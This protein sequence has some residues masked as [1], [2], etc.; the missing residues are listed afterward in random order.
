MVNLV[1]KHTAGY[2]IHVDDNRKTFKDKTYVA[3]V[4]EPNQLHKFASY[5]AL[6]TLSAL[7]KSDLENT[8]FMDGAPHDII[9]R[10]SGIADGNLASHLEGS[11]S[12]Q[13]KMRDPNYRKT[14]SENER[15]SA[16]L[17]KSART[18]K[19]DRDMYFQSVEIKA[20]P[21]PNEKRRLTSVV[22]MT[23]NIIE[24]AGIT[25]FEKLR[26]AAF[27]NG[28]FDHIDHP[29]LLTVEFTGFDTN[30]RIMTSNETKNMKRLIP[31]KLIDVQMSVNQ[32]GTEYSVKAIP[33]NEFGFM[34]RF[35]YVRTS[36]TLK[37]RNR[38]L[39]T[40][41][42]ALENLL[43]E[44]NESE[45]TTAGVSIPDIY[46]ISIDRSFEADKVE[47]DSKSIE[48]AGM[49]KQ[50]DVT[51]AD[52]GFYG[53]D[54]DIPTIDVMKVNTGNAISKI[55]EDIMKSHPLL[56]DV[57]FDKWKSK[58]ASTLLG[59]QQVSGSQGVY[60][61]ATDK[62]NPDM[63]FPYFKVKSAVTPLDR[64]D[65]KRQKHQKLIHFIVEPYEVHAYSLAIPGVSTGD[66]F[67]KFVYKTY[68]YMFTGENVDVL[69]C[70][71]DYKYS[72]FQSRLK[73]VDASND[74]QNFVE[75]KSIEKQPGIANEPDFVHDGAFKHSFEPGIAANEKTGP[76][77]ETF[78]RV[79]QFIDELTH[80]L[81]DMV[82]IRL[83]ILGDPAWIGQSQFIPP[84]PKKVGDGITQDTDIVYWRG[85]K[86]EAIWNSK[87]KCYNTDLAEPI[88]MLRFK[89]PTDVDTKK[90]VYEMGVTEQA[91]FSGLYRVISMEHNF[92][93]GKYT[94]ILELTRFNNQGV[95]ISDPIEDYQTTDFK[96]KVTVPST[97]EE[98]KNFKDNFIAGATERVTNIGK[99]VVKD[100]TA[101]AKKIF[102]G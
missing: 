92:V 61:K 21:G 83:E 31:V 47:V 6:F 36:G 46:K 49:T 29:F 37:P 93:D 66:N 56:T 80:P 41:F 98:I 35:N 9:L 1:A 24:P 71:I 88:I 52:A 60:N 79:D 15:M 97:K 14:L 65:N 55:L 13:E 44:Q 68:N 69:D 96:S 42:T 95:Y 33:Y 28:S 11:A 3:D 20:L 32:G 54:D 84:V 19:R 90:G 81:A 48:Q 16:T 101:E 57:N 40:V 7:S 18:F 45:K 59:V 53:P 38:K 17:A 85:G 67:K 72:Y 74:R 77:G 64:Y 27:N 75:K 58:V 43:N 4:S 25:L 91:M 73:D 82:N 2:N 100:L 34:N 70:N 87:L 89:M 8:K 94:N 30:G 5:N 22:Q 26:A 78:T 86:R 62:E 51:G 102:R 99:N 23:M 63:Y 50:T 10:S 12:A 39:N 76:T